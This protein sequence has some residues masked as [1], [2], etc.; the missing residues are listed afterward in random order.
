MTSEEF[1]PIFTEFILKHKENV[2]RLAYSYVHNPQ[3]AL[4]VVSDS[5]Q[6]A[7]SKNDSLTKPEAIKSW[8]Y[9]IVVNT[10]LDFIRKERKI[11]YMDDDLLEFYGS[12]QLDVT[13]DIDLERALEELPQPLREV[14][15]LRFFED[16]KIDEVAAVLGLPPSTVK[17]RLY[18]A[19]ELLRI[20]M[21]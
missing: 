15:I 10:A 14:I 20:N 19:L 9:R 3:N 2:Y 11:Q 5:V 8:F 7:L 18:K 4:D 13:A 12:A 21:E 16:L 6:K 17:T 1:H